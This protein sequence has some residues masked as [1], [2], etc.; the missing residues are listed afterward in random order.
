MTLNGSA[1]KLPLASCD[2]VY[3]PAR[4]SPRITRAIDGG[5]IWPRVPDAQIVPHA[6]LWSY[7][8]RSIVGRLRRP[9]VTT[10]AP[11]IPVDAAS[12][13][14]TK[15]TEM[16]RPPCRGPKH[17]P[18]VLNS[19]SAT[20]ERSSMTPMNTNRGTA[21]RISLLMIPKKRDGNAV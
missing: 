11:T 18:I 12:S 3:V 5:M 16:P 7:P 10:V 9:M 8:A 20:F 6:S 19:S 15:V 14:P 4:V 1:I 13:I 17:C 2:S 21:T